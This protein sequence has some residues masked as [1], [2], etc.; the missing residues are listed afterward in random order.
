MPR[1]ATITRKTKETNIKLS[2]NL[3]GTGS[4]QSKHLDPFCG[5]HA[6][7]YVETRAYRFKC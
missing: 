6:G 7:S 5:P 3:D 1:K 2:I 4:L